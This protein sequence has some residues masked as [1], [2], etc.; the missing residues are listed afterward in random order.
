M[1]KLLGLL[2]GSLFFYFSSTAQDFGYRTNDV[3][4]EIQKY[5]RGHIY[6][7]HT[8]FNTKLHHSFQLKFGY[9]R[10][11]SYKVG[12]YAEF[13]EGWGGG[14]GYRYYFN[15]VAKRFFAGI[16][17]DVWVMKIGRDY[18]PAGGPAYFPSNNLT[19]QPHAEAGY[20]FLINELV[21]ITPYLSAGFQ[22][23][24]DEHSSSKE[25]GTGF[26]PAAGI[27]AGFRF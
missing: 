13:G 20:T 14:I 23:D 19:L 15:P 22:T 16:N 5:S 26:I 12:T 6:S 21:Y 17:A 11:P 8:A 24:F 4:V 3:G 27:R 9:N 18:S 7:L 2:S 10:V 1:K 25:Y